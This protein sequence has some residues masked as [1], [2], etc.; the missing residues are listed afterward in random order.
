M[1]LDLV[2]AG[3]ALGVAWLA[4]PW[5]A[6]TPEGPP[7]PWLVWT[8]VMPWCWAVDRWGGMPLLQPL[9]G[10][11]LLVLMAGWPLAML[12]LLPVTLATVWL[13][14]LGW[15]PA[16]SRAVWLGVVPGS[17][18]L[19]FGAGVRRLLP[20]HLFVYILGRGFFATAL[21]CSLAASVPLLWQVPATGTEVGDLLLA[22]GLTAW[23][24]AFLTGMLVAIGVAFRPQWLATYSDSLY[25]PR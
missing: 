14:G 15:E 2:L 20:H 17:L 6:L 25:L 18:T 21:S 3:S 22:R 19:L 4:R 24:E 13:S 9:S 23:G 5:R 11:C 10:A 12:A 16:L 1:G 7:W 8:L